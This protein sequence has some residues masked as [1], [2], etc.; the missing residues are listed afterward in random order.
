LETGTTIGGIAVDGGT[1]NWGNGRY[2]MFTEPAPGYHGMNFWEVFGP[3]G[4][5]GALPCTLQPGLSAG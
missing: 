5:T 2:P 3:G 4:T 1:F